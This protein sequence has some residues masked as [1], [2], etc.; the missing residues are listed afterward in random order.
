MKNWDKVNSIAKYF[1]MG[2]IELW[3]CVTWFSILINVVGKT[4]TWQSITLGSIIAVILCILIG[5][6]GKRW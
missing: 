1:V 4:P 2:V 3:L 6:I 5:F